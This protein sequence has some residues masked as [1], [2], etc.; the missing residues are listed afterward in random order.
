MSYVNGVKEMLFFIL[1]ELVYQFK[2]ERDYV[3]EYIKEVVII[4]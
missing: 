3:V 4:I 1:F 2:M